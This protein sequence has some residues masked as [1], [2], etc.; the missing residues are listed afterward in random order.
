MK[1]TLRTIALAMCVIAAPIAALAAGQPKPEPMPTPDLGSK[2]LHNAID[3]EVNKYGQV[4][5]IKGGQLSHDPMFDTMTIGNA[6][7]M[8][9]R[10]PDG[11]AVAG[12]F[13]VSYDYDPHTHNIIRR[14][15]MIYAGGT[16]ASE[17]GA[18]TK[19]IAVAKRETQ[20]AYDRLKADEKHREQESAKHLPDI[21]AAVKRALATPTPHP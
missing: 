21:N 8:W 2:P 17:P 12:L 16:W 20:E 5:R 11:T 15:G 18:A 7:Q 14:P 9:I 3:V 10:H 4:V 13:R 19:M 1:S 6:L